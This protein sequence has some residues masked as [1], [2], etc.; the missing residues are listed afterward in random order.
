MK[1]LLLA[2]LVF[3]LL[4]A[5]PRAALAADVALEAPG[6][7]TTAHLAPGATALEVV[8]RVVNHEARPVEVE[9]GLRGGRSLVPRDP[10]GVRA[11]FGDGATRVTLAP[12]EARPAVVRWS[13]PFEAR[14]DLVNARVDVRA[15]DGTVRSLRVL[16]RTARAERFPWSFG[17]EGLG[18]APLLGALVVL[19]WRSP[20]VLALPWVARAVALAQLGILAAFARVLDPRL[21]RSDGHLGYLAYRELPWAA[22]ALDAPALLSVAL[23]SVG[24]VVAAWLPGSPGPRRREVWLLAHLAHSAAVL[25][26]LAADLRALVAAAA[27]GASV[28][29]GAFALFVSRRAAVR[30]GLFGALGVALLAAASAAL[31]RAAGSP[32]LMDVAQIDFAREAPWLGLPAPAGHFLVLLLAASF[33]A[34]CWPLGAWSA[35]LPRLPAPLAAVLTSGLCALGPVLGVRLGAT[36]LF[37]GAAY[38]APALAAGGIVIALL[39]A[40][41]ALG[42]RRVGDLAPAA[43]AV[44]GGVLLLGLGGCTPI[45]AQAALAAGPVGGVV[46]TLLVAVDALLVERVGTSEIDRL[47]GIASSSPLLALALVA[48][49]AGLAAAP[50]T[51]GFVPVL[52]A[53]D[54]ALPRTPLVTAAFV[55]PWVLLALTATRIALRVLPG[56]LPAELARASRLEPHGGRVAPLTGGERGALALL[57][58]AVVLLGVVPRPLLAALDAAALDLGALLDPPGPAQ[59]VRAPGRQPP[60]A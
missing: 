17:L 22:L 4:A 28:V 33:F 24:L 57:L 49:L 34:P 5:V 41:L 7:A 18:L 15:A 31:A 25:A 13:P 6:G 32:L 46:A 30:A 52:L 3:A 8:L 29:V 50:G 60:P 10:P 36:L 48:G 43:L 16:G 37:E 11:T 53:L 27:L 1:R 20:R 12:N 40:W 23:A 2:L 59:I 14:S 38:A 26:L 42:A 51:L 35:A 39:G 19:L 55:V 9:I 21:G 54:G 58:A 47:A 45:G 56:T 44:Q